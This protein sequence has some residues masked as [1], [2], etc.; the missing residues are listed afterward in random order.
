MPKGWD[1]LVVSIVSAE[2]GKTVAKT[3]KAAARNGSCQWADT[4]SESIRFSE[5][6]S[7]KEIE[8]CLFKLIVSMV[9]CR[10]HN[11]CVLF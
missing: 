5:H 10:C 8:D 6:D 9:T 2:T 11:C 7:A 1:K 3:S 4:L